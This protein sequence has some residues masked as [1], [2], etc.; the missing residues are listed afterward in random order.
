[1]QLVGLDRRRTAELATF[2]ALVEAIAGH[3]A[4]RW[5]SLCAGESC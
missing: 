3:F 2:E 4:S 5:P 1:M